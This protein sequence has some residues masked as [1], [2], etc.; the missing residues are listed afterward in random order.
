MA[1]SLYYRLK[2]VNRNIKVLFISAL[3]ASAELISILPEVQLDNILKKPIDRNLFISTVKAN[4][5]DVTD[6]QIVTD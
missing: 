3:D 5:S 2:A 1:C 6:G 4:L